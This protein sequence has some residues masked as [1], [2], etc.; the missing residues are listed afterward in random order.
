MI[1]YH[2]K[3]EDLHLYSCPLLIPRERY[4]P[5]EGY[6]IIGTATLLSILDDRYLVTAKH[7]ADITDEDHLLYPKSDSEVELFKGDRMRTNPVFETMEAPAKNFDIAV[8][9]LGDVP[10]HPKF[11]FLGRGQ[12]APNEIVPGD[13]S[14]VL[15][16][17][18]GGKNKTRPKSIYVKSNEVA[19][20]FT[21]IEPK[22]YEKYGLD[23]RY[24]LAVKHDR[25]VYT[26]KG[27]KV[28]P[29]KMKGMSGGP[30]WIDAGDG[31][32]LT[33]ITTD[34]LIEERIVFGTRIEIA[35]N[36]VY[37]LLRMKNENT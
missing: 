26:D 8:L 6:E 31:Y 35:V 17:Y 4:K 13:I 36:A 33:A 22:E 10:I 11:R 30:M 18:P 23:P 3:F 1:L 7:V 34:H 37:E 29:P 12:L 24:H 15:T 25:E 2:P 20:Y 16:G 32:V 9:R 5:S 19:W 21:T 27:Q 28:R 14:C